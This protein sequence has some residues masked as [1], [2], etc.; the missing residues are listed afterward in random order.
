[1]ENSDADVL[2]APKYIV[3]SKGNPFITT[4]EVSVTGYAGYIK[5]IK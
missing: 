5:S 4:V 3:K 1:M 2:V